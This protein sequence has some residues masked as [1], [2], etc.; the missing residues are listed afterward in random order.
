MSFRMTPSPNDM[1]DGTLE[2]IVAT[3][4][5]LTVAEFKRLGDKA[6]YHYAD[7]S[8][9]E[10]EQADKA[11]AEALA[12]FDAHPELEAQFREVGLGFLWLLGMARPRK[13]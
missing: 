13:S 7:D 6:S 5:Q 10:W 4:E 8:T 12:V 11:K 1:S 9:R 2:Q 3:A